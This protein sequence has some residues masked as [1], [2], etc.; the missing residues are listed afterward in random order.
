MKKL[1]Y[2]IVLALILGLVLTGCTLLSNV[3]QVPSTEQSGITYL[4][5]GLPGEHDVFTLYAGQTI[6]VGTVEVWNDAGDLYVQ[7]VVDDPWEM[8]GSHLY[9]GKTD[10]TDPVE[11]PST[12]GQLPYSPG[13][14]KSPSPNASYDDATMTYTIPLAEIYCYEFV[15]KGQGKGLNAI[16][17]S[18]VGS[19]DEIYIAAQAEVI[20][21]IDDCYEPEPVWQIGDVEGMQTDNPYDEFNWPTIVPDPQEKDFYVGTTFKLFPY[22]SWYP[23]S[24]TTI[25]IYF[26][27]EMLLGGRFLFSWSPGNSGK[28]TIEVSL[29]GTKFGEVTRSGAFTPDWYKDQERFID[30]FDDV[31]A[32]EAGEHVLTINVTA[33]D[34]LVW[35]WLKLEEKCIQEETAWAVY[36]DG[37]LKFGKNWATYFT[38]TVQGWWDLTG[39]YVWQFLYT[40]IPSGTILPPIPY[41]HD[42]DVTIH[43]WHTTG[44]FEGV[45]GY[46]AGGPYTVTWEMTGKVDGDDVEFYID[47]DGSGYYI[48][49]TG[50][51]ALGGSMSGTCETPQ[52][53]PYDWLTISGVATRRP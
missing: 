50:T 39:T 29:G 14:A 37:V 47:Y 13:M 12:P 32:I 24:A 48:D 3:G 36:D 49:A 28:E 20:R 43:Q 17:P 1:Y 30:S 9:V 8:T 44:D 46:P 19:C 33:G 25:N 16:G 2:L 7:Y 45:G 21:P 4:T 6:P 53:S 35:D 15:R 26:N 51:I 41:D 18:G 10:P 23:D 52:G 40:G 31:P 27:A 11:F 5:K 38:Y 34:G 22:L 42:M